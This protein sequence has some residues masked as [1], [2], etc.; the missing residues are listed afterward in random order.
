LGVV[1]GYQRLDQKKIK[2]ARLIGLPCVV[3]GWGLRKP[4]PSTGS[5]DANLLGSRFTVF[6][7]ESLDASAHVVHGFL[8][9]RVK[10]MGFTG[11][12]QFVKG[13]LATIIHL[14]HLFGIGARARYKFKAVGEVN[15]TD[16]SVIGVN[17]FFH[18]E[19]PSMSV[20]SGATPANPAHFPC[21]AINYIDF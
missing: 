6:V 16:V 11:G 2:A 18:G 20:L 10:G 21:K 4:A 19:C 8:C 7:A 15:K 14:D 12:V 17:A 3:T 1:I 13:Q 5:N 9:A